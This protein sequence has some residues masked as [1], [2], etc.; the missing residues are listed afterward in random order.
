MKPVLSRWLHKFA[1]EIPSS[2]PKFA[3][4]KPLLA[5]LGG[6]CPRCLQ[7]LNGHRFQIYAMTVA[8]PERQDALLDFLQKARRH[9]WE[10]LACLQEFDPLKNSL[11][12]CALQCLDQNLS[13]L[14]ICDPF[15]LLGGDSLE[16]W[17]RMEEPMAQSWLTFLDRNKW[18]SLG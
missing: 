15:E 17:E 13:M 6:E 5:M 12:V 4:S 11:Q 14:L 3:V 8:S 10:S 18:V 7:A 16:S 2:E 1:G 9:Q